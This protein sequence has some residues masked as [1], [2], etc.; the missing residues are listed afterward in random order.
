[1]KRSVVNTKLIQQSNKAVILIDCGPNTYNRPGEM[2]IMIDA[3]TLIALDRSQHSR[4]GK[5]RKYA[6]NAFHSS[7]ICSIYPASSHSIDRG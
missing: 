3:A 2:L 4:A 7:V 1:M 6:R 5:R